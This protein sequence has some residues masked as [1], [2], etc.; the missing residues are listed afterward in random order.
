MNILN[1]L[2]KFKF[3]FLYIREFLISKGKRI[4]KVTFSLLIVLFIYFE[5]KSE[6]SSLNLTASLSLLR[7]FEPI[8]LLLFF[9][10]G[11][12]AVSCMTFYDYFII[13]NLKYKISVLKTFR[14]SWISNTFKNKINFRL[15]L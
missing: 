4:L 6:L 9:I 13:K 3:I 2:P 15:N 14:I 8:K 12:A 10:A 11:S 1:I 7:S 5:G